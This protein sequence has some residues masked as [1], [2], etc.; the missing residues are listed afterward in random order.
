MEVNRIDR[1][2]VQT[3]ARA[4]QVHDRL[5]RAREHDGVEEPDVVQLAVHREHHVDIHADPSVAGEP[6]E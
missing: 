5:V 3:L 6:H 2:N 1:L 4:R